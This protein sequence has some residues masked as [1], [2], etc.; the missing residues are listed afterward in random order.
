MNRHQLQIA[1]GRQVSLQANPIQCNF[2]DHRCFVALTPLMPQRSP[3]QWLLDHLMAADSII[4]L[5]L[6]FPLEQFL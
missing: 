1:L 3:S 5:L 6:M 2:Q 4:P